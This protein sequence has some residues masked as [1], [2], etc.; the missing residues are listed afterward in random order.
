[1]LLFIFWICKIEQY[2]EHKNTSPY[3]FKYKYSFEK[4]KKIID[5]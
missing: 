4:Q 1:M 2:E 5:E 3:R